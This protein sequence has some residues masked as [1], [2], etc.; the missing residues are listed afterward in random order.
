MKGLL[1]LYLS[2]LRR[3]KKSSWGKNSIF[4]ILGI[5][6]AVGALTLAMILFESYEETLSNAFK[7]SQPDISIINNGEEISEYQESTLRKILDDYESDIKALDGKYQ[8]SV[9]ISNK[10]F[11]KPAF[12][13]SYSDGNKDY[14]KY[15]YSFSKQADFH[16]G[17]NEIILGEYLAKELQVEVGEK[18]EVIL[19]S[20]IRYSLF[21][22]VK[23]SEK[24]LVKEIYKTGLYEID[25]SR[26]ILSKDTIKKITGNKNSASSYSILLNNRKNDNSNLITS[27]INYQLMMSLPSMY[28]ID[29]FS[30]NSM[31][32]SALSLQK[33]MIFLILCIIII[34]AGFNVI[35]TVSTIIN[36][37]INEI[38]I[39]MTLGLKRREIKLI[40]FVFSLL[41]AHLGIILGLLGGYAS[42]YWLTHQDY[43][44]LK[45]DIYFIDKIMIHPSIS[46]FIIIYA[47]TVVIIAMTILFTLRSINKLEI[48]KIMRQ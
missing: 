42:A 14:N 6:I 37:K 2:S 19:P 3:I 48:I 12:I 45:G 29:L 1:S 44:S 32:F 47:T 24:F 35:S 8:I 7:V 13:E 30:N 38:G 46:M 22:L 16:L 43:I 40:Y 15:L 21:G 5:V 34:V 11:N 36:E 23:K 39:L 26:A 4:M 18:V 25:A 27:K 33:I 17:A 10:E 31:I 20:S 28:A 41:L 9:I